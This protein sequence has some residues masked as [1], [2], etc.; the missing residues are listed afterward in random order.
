MKLQFLKELDSSFTIITKSNADLPILGIT[1]SKKILKHHLVFV[2][3]KQFFNELVEKN[4]EK[5]SLGLVLEKKY[6]DSLTKVEVDQI[7]LNVY[8]LAYVD[9]VNI[10]MSKVSKSFYDE[11]YPTP[12]DVVDGRQM[13]TASIHPSTW[14]AQ[15]V[16]IGENVKVEANVKIHPGCVLMSGAIVGEGSELYPNVTLYRNVVLGKNVRIHSGTVIGADGFGYNF[17]QGQHLKVWHMGSVIIGNDIEIGANSTIDSGTFSPTIIKDGCKFD[18][19][20]HVGHNCQIGKGVILC[21]GVLLG[22][23]TTLGDYVV[24]GGMSGAS[25]G[26]EIGMGAQVGAMSGVTNNIQAKQ[27]VAGFPARDIKEW[28]KSMAALRKLALGKNKES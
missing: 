6:F 20:V 27:T 11:K 28:I 3:N 18:N 9:D 16:F 7:I 14:I 12:N 25:N 8:F 17:H 10:S 19:L 24:M 26:I 21:G 23:S 4:I 13:G 5:I 22:G 1:D 15:G 2:K